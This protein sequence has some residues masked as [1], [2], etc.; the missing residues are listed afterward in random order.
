M[1]AHFFF[2]LKILKTPSINPFT[3]FFILVAGV[4][5]GIEALGALRLVQSFF[6][7]INIGLQTIE[8]YFLP[9]VASLYH[10]SVLEAKK[11]L[12]QITFFGLVVLGTLLSI[13]FVFSKF[14]RIYAEKLRSLQEQPLH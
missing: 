4:Y 14:N 3:N 12:V 13:L 10:Q 6:G 11:Y 1:K 9:K 7:I 2:I 8:N 5:L